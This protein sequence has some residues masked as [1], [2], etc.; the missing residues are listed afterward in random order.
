MAISREIKQKAFALY[1]QEVPI[2]EIAELLGLRS[3]QTV[4]KWIKKENWDESRLEII[5]ITKEKG[6][7]AT[8]ERYMNIAKAIMSIYAQA[9]EKNK[10]K[11]ISRTTHR[12]AIEAVKLARLIE[13][14]STEN[15]NF[16]G[17]V[18]LSIREAL[19]QIKDEEK[20]GLAK[21]KR[22]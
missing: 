5:K 7:K 20:S 13:G 16:S 11:M 19:K 14:D 9:I 21:K 8:K 3:R 6:T 22:E 1:C 10:D 17:E 18:N 4:Y 12:D 15:V 2:Q